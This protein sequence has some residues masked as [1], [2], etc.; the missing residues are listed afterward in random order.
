MPAS[1]R[2]HP[3]IKNV[4]NA[5]GWITSNVASWTSKP[6]PMRRLAQRILRS[7]TEGSTLWFFLPEGVVL[8][9]GYIVYEL[10]AAAGNARKFIRLDQA[11]PLSNFVMR[12]ALLKIAGSQ[13]AVEAL[14][15][16]IG[17]VQLDRLWFGNGP[18]VLHP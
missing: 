12:G 6:P 8:K 2:G 14:A 1:M 13:V 18:D 15:I 7:V 11:Q 4:T 5:K 9:R 3:T 10:M 17:V 16:V